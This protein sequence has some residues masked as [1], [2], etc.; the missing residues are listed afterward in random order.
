MTDNAPFLRRSLSVEIIV[1]PGMKKMNWNTAQQET[2]DIAGRR[3]SL[4]GYRIA[5]DVACYGDVSA[6][7]A[8]IEV[9]NLPESLM[10]SLSGYGGNGVFTYAN[11]V[12]QTKGSGVVKVALFA[13]QDTTDTIRGSSDDKAALNRTRVFYGALINASAQMKAV[14][15]PF[16]HIQ[17]NT[18]NT[19]RVLPAQVIS[20]RG[21]VGASVIARSIA[22]SLGVTFSDGGVTTTLVNPYFTGS[23]ADQLRKCAEQGL[24]HYVLDQD[25]LTIWPLGQ[26]RPASGSGITI[27]PQNGLIEYPEF[28]GIGI[29][30][31]TIYNPALR[32]GDVITLQSD[33][34]NAS[35]KYRV[36]SIAHHLSAQV[37]DGPWFT[38]IS[39][40]FGNSPLAQAP[41]A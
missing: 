38:V 2:S 22:D 16:L 28:N 37:P 8:S 35:G 39:A 30:F 12:G 10:K 41:G 23:A 11:N 40:S 20:Y 29:T 21:A 18:L 7:E 26:G 4:T 5:A 17:C 13:G 19:A 33:A 15:E 6:V 36:Y 32:Y 9:Y 31:T 14:P 3:I 24:F 34:P 27:T 25:T 1:P